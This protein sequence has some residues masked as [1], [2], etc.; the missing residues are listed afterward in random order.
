MKTD[1]LIAILAQDP[2]P[3]KPPITLGALGIL[4]AVLSCVLTK[5]WLGLRP[6]LNAMT[7][8]ASFCFKTFILGSLVI[9]SLHAL[10]A[11]S[12]PLGRFTLKH[13]AIGLA[14]LFLVALG[15]EWITKPAGEIGKLFLL[16]NFG[17]CLLFV[18][19]YGAGVSIVLLALIKHAAPLHYGRTAGFIGL[20]SACVGA[21]GYSIHCPVDSPTFMLIAYGLP[22][23]M[24]YMAS[25]FLL[26]RFLRW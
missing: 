14:A 19:L 21:L 22:Q 7:I 4:L 6:E 16:P 24:L 5:F 2:S 8:P 25:R 3:K 9:L 20:A 10:K 1:E 17:D 13:F 15:Y 26:A 12:V 23:L 11:S 18:T